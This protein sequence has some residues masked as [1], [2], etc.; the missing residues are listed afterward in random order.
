MRIRTTESTPSPALRHCPLDLIHLILLPAP[1]G[2]G[3]V[4]PRPPTRGSSLDLLYWKSALQIKS[5]FIAYLIEII[6]T[7]LAAINIW[8]QE[9]FW[10]CNLHEKKHQWNMN[11]SLLVAF[12]V[13]GQILNPQ[14]ACP[15]LHCY[16]AYWCCDKAK[17]YTVWGHTCDLVTCK[18]QFGQWKIRC[19]KNSFSM[20]RV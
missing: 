13:V 11:I 18:L 12:G 2:R 15:L 1:T 6:H 7:Y 4:W 8:W 9:G 16:C 5:G 20:N 3:I 19:K 14:P 17:D 10:V